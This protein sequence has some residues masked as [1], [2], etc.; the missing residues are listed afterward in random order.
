MLIGT[1]QENENNLYEDLEI[2]LNDIERSLD[3]LVESLDA[4]I[5]NESVATNEK[6]LN[7]SDTP[8]IFDKVIESTNST[9]EYL[10]EAFSTS[11][12]SNNDNAEN[13]FQNFEIS[14]A[15]NIDINDLIN[16]PFLNL[17]KEI[18]KSTPV[19]QSACNSN[20]VTYS[21]EKERFCSKLNGA[22]KSIKESTDVINR[23]EAS[24]TTFSE[25]LEDKNIIE[26]STKTINTNT[27]IRKVIDKDYLQKYTDDMEQ[28]IRYYVFCIYAN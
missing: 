10:P 7:P 18:R 4:D 20:S 28:V 14:L 13:N 26:E 5:K 3:N 23:K 16:N 12:E 24:K 22:L 8:D 25:L 11:T 2:L 27:E 9:D 21:S 6:T 1:L 19:D 17:F 15:A